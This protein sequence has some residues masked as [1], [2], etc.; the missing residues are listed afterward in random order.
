M[1][2]TPAS[3]ARRPADRSAWSTRGLARARAAAIRLLGGGTSTHAAAERVALAVAR[4]QFRHGLKH[5][6]AVAADSL[7]R[8]LHGR[9]VVL[10]VREIGT[11]SVYLW[12]SG[13]PTASGVE[14]VHLQRL[15]AH[16][17]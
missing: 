5:T 10:V 11:G 7:L 14:P 8:E 3:E 13:T 12:R 4:V 17:A 1:Q 2:L 15:Q 9:R 6:L 16:E